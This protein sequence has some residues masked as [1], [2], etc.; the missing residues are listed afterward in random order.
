[1]NNIEKELEAR[2]PEESM[3]YEFFKNTS[4]KNSASS[5]TAKA[6]WFHVPYQNDFREA[7]EKALNSN[8]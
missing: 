4:K 3:D 5:V 2:E 8:Y 6:M 1:M 7:K